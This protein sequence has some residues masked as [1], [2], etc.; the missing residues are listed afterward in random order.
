MIHNALQVNFQSALDVFSML[1]QKL[2]QEGPL[3]R[4]E[5]R[6]ISTSLLRNK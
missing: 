1:S 2:E 4:L 6:Q 3:L 5:M